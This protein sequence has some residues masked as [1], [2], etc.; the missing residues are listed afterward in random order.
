MRFRQRGLAGQSRRLPRKIR[1]IRDIPDYLDIAC[2]VPPCIAPRHWNQGVNEHGKQGMPRQPVRRLPWMHPRR[3]FFVI[4]NS[5]A[6]PHY[7][8]LYPVII[9]TVRMILHM[10]T[11]LL[12][13]CI[14]YVPVLLA[15]HACA[16]CRLDAKA[17]GYARFRTVCGLF[18]YAS[19][20]PLRKA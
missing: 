1:K 15:R 10:R 20:M 12:A 9:A 5:N 11:A 2:R 18:H 6:H 17:T 3:M 8:G 19:N 4:A 13:E 16:P 7:R 14:L